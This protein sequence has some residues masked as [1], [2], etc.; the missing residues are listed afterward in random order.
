MFDIIDAIFSAQGFN[1]SLEI[2]SWKRAV[3]VVESSKADI[4]PG[5]LN[6]DNYPN[7]SFPEASISQFEACFIS[8][9]SSVWRYLNYSSLV[10]KKIGLING[11]DYDFVEIIKLIDEF[12]QNIYYLSGEKITERAM[13]MLMH[14]H[15]STYLDDI[16]I[17]RYKIK[18]NH[19]QDKINIAGCLS[20]SLRKVYIG[21]TASDKGRNLAFMFDNGIGDLRR[22]GKLKSILEKYDLQDWQSQ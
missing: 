8:S 17:A 14:G 7:L 5:I 19:W 20:Q 1:V 9:K 11:Y 10:G 6:G 2:V 18:Q 16:N 4:I 13:K 15:I 22:S 12:P 3:S 21:F